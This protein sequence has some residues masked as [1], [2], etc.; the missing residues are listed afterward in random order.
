MAR[1]G[2][3]RAGNPQESEKSATSAIPNF[4]PRFDPY[5]L[6]TVFDSASTALDPALRMSIPLVE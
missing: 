2:L 5:W 1:V 4:D 6:G 3:A